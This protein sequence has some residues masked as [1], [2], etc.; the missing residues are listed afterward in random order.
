MKPILIFSVILVL[1]SC[2]P[3]DTPIT[4]NE[5]IW[6]TWGVPHI[7][8]TSDAD[9]YK[10]M[11][12][13]Q[14]KNHG[15]LILKLYGE[16]RGMSS[17]LWEGDATRDEILHTL[18]LVEN[19]EKIYEGLEA[20]YK[21]IVD[22]FTTG[23]NAYVTKHKST[24]NEKY[25]AV[26]PLQPID[27]IA[28]SNRVMY[29]EFLINRAMG[30]ASEWEPGSNAWAITDSKSTSGNS[31]LLANPHL[32]WEDFWLFFESQMITDDNSLYGATLVGMPTIGI[33]FNEYLGWTHTVNTLDNVDLYEINVRDGEYEIDGEW[34][35]FE[36]K[37]I[38]FSTKE[39]D[40]VIVQKTC[41]YGIVVK[42][43]S[44]KALAIRYPN[45][46]ASMNP[47][48]QWV[49]MGAAKSLEEFQEALKVNTI[50]LFNV[51]YADHDGNILYHF[52]GNIPKKNGDWER[53]QDVVA[54]SSSDDVWT[55][56]Y[57]FGEVPAYINPESDWI[58]NANDPPYTSTVPAT[59]LPGDFP[60]HIAPNSM[61][62]RPQRSATLISQKGSLS[63]EEFINLKHDTKSQMALRIQDDLAALT[64]QAP[65]SLTRAAL[66]LMSNWDGT[67][68]AD[69]KGSLLFTNMIL[70]TRSAGLFKEEWDF[71][72]PL[73]TPDGF[74][75]PEYVLGLVKATAERLN[76]TF[77][78]I[79][80]PYGD[81]FR[82]R[83][84]EY[85]FPANGGFGGLGIFRTMNYIPGEDGK[86]YAYHGDSYV[87]TMEFSKPVRAKAILGYGN[88]TQPG[89]PHVGD[90]L[91]LYSKKELRDVWLTRKDHEANLELRETLEDM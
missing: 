78:A 50:P 15:D 6:D 76:Q 52:G 12:W 40:G 57:D 3:K 74:K 14:M 8:A 25:T 53:W 79:D 22:A 24:L 18:G 65:D 44:N 49:R 28:H 17:F 20:E 84:G 66:D 31:L 38:P 13:A 91:E 69:S 48:S 61:S 56:Y 1:I 43:S 55:E 62:F 29:Y 67:F 37:E 2:Q 88:A 83:V 45:M 63:F 54:T 72:N 58:Q 10:M 87:C 19:A 39:T 68:N 80:V 89:N 7:Y 9:L 26:L 23:M 86:Y 30:T 59:I 85:E 81:V 16:A 47:F 64:D 82:V 21:E 4:S 42:E 60:S 33:G 75:Q 32:P 35:K 71:D 73:S 11:G 46:D 34:K 70:S 27:V 90:Q 41:D 5:I 77:G 36:E 51:V